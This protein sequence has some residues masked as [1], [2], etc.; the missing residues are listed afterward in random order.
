MAGAAS[1]DL[2]GCSQERGTVNCIRFVNAFNFYVTKNNNHHIMSKEKFSTNS[3]A[4]R[5]NQFRGGKCR[6]FEY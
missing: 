5:P 4:T 2:G 3:Y 6:D 1:S